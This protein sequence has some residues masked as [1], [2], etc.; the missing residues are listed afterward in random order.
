MK[1]TRKSKGRRSVR[2]SSQRKSAPWRDLPFA[3]LFLAESLDV[4]AAIAAGNV[5]ALETSLLVLREVAS[6]FEKAGA[7][8]LSAWEG[9]SDKE[10]KELLARYV[11]L[12]LC[13]Y[14]AGAM[15]RE[16]EQCLVDAGRVARSN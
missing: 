4:D 12:R 7:K 10:R 11:F 8:L 1:R 6:G 14:A 13:Q 3:A 15:V 9:A 5:S 16:V 2:A